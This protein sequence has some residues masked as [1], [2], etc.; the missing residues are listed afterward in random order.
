MLW[1]ARRA[2]IMV[3]RR[4]GSGRHQLDPVTDV[5]EGHS[6]H[7]LSLMELVWFCHQTGNRYVQIRRNLGRRMTFIMI[8]GVSRLPAGNRGCACSVAKACLTLCFSVD[9]SPPGSSVCGI[10]HTRIL[11]W[12]AILSSRRSSRFR[13]RICISYSSCIG[14]QILY[15]WATWEVQQRLCNWVIW[16]ELSEGTVCKSLSRCRETKKGQLPASRNRQG[17]QVLWLSHMCHI[18]LPR[19]EVG[20]QILWLFS[21]LLHFPASVSG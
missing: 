4:E 13:D 8:S 14:R 2:A 12:V 11:K 6:S 17:G 7:W 3:R 15:H 5:W 10:I 19:E 9:C 21:S 18:Q 20:E 16:S 1:W